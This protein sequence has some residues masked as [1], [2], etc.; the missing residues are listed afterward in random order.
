MPIENFAD[1]LKSIK[2]SADNIVIEFNSDDCYDYASKVWNWVNDDQNNTMTLVT[3]AG[4][5]DPDED[6]D[7]FR[8]S[9]VKFEKNGLKA[10]LAAKRLS[11][12]EAAHDFSF[13]TSNH[14]NAVKPAA[15]RRFD[16]WGGVKDTFNDVKDGVKDTFDD[17]KD[18][19]KETVE[20]LSTIEKQKSST[21]N[22]DFKYDQNLFD[23]GKEKYG[24]SLKAG[25]QAK[26][27][28]QLLVDLDIKVVKFEPK[29]LKMKLRPKGLNAQLMLALTA[30]GELGKT[31]IKYNLPG[32]KIPVASISIPKVI[33]LGPV[34]EGSIFLGTSKLKGV[35]TASVGGKAK[36]SDNA[37]LEIDAL[38]KNGNTAKG[39]TPEFEK[40]APQFSASLEGGVRAGISLSIG[41]E[42]SILNKCK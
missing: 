36:F 37:V 27:G 21:M 3:K 30:S 9:G 11:W 16:L 28:G 13:T 12:E 39:W 33:Q 4:Q 1:R 32:V 2:C 38:N 5:C 41:F 10:T 29:T 6:R 25:A 42:A 23:Y 14:A 18:G 22:I 17:V 40:I 24:M 7:P 8:I 19:V 15:Q 20:D 34:V 35:A 31:P 26:T